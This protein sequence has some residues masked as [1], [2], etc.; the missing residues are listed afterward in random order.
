[1]TMQPRRGCAVKRVPA[2]GRSVNEANGSSLP[3]DPPA[4]AAAARRA[5]TPEAATY[6]ETAAVF[7]PTHDNEAAWAEWRFMPRVARDVAGV[8][9]AVDL[10]GVRMRAPILLA[11][12]VFAGHAHPDGELAVARAA[13]VTGSTYVVSSSSSQPPE[14]VA[15]QRA[16]YVLA[17]ALRSS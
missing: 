16:G 13:V 10:L 5:L 2:Y 7:P 11:P 9:T 8:T 4:L 14:A 3:W 15:A 1:M 17:P 6:Y 12:C